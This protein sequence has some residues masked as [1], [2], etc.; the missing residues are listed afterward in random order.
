MI[1]SR[2]AVHFL[3]AIRIRVKVLQNIIHL[4]KVSFKRIDVFASCLNR[5]PPSLLGA[6]LPRWHPA[7]KEG[8]VRIAP[9]ALSLLL[10]E[11]SEPR[12]MAG[13]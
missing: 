1:P 4:D 5:P 12:T 3:I 10:S 2:T 7:E 13:G 8:D 11:R 6:T 9:G